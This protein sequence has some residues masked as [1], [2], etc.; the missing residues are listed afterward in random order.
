MATSGARVD[1]PLPDELF[2]WL[3]EANLSRDGQTNAILGVASAA[4]RDC[5][6]RWYNFHREI[7]SKM[8]VMAMDLQAANKE[9]KNVPTMKT[10]IATL[11]KELPL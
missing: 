8:D 3:G 1:W 10:R 4:V 5:Y 6:T 7:V 2:E 9:K 11:E